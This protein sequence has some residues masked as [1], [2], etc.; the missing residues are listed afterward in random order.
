MHYI[1]PAGVRDS[2]RMSKREQRIFSEENLRAVAFRMDWDDRRANMLA[3]RE[4][5]VKLLVY[6]AERGMS[7]ARL[8]QIWGPDFVRIVLDGV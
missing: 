6:S 2:T 1:T 7:R 8:C 5:S 3:G 4:N